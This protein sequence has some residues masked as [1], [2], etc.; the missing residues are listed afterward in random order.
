MFKEKLTGIESESAENSGS[1]IEREKELRGCSGRR[2][3]SRKRR[4]DA[5]GTTSSTEGERKK[6]ISKSKIYSRVFLLFLRILLSGLLLSFFFFVALLRHLQN[7][8]WLCLLFTGDPPVGYR[9]L[10]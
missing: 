2:F 3:T 8:G 9:V 10:V 5:S 1:S 4:E 7:A 6:V